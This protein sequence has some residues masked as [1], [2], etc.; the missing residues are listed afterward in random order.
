MMAWITMTAGNYAV[1]EGGLQAMTRNLS[2]K[3]KV[4]Q[5][6]ETMRWV[7]DCLEHLRAPPDDATMARLF[8]DAPRPRPPQAPQAPSAKRSGAPVRR[9]ASKDV[10]KRGSSDP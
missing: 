7:Q 2:L 4:E 10:R 1:G 3:F 8:R 6:L 5:S 9:L